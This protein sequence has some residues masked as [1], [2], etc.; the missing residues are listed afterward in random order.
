MGVSVLQKM[1]VYGGEGGGG[2]E[3]RGEGGL[4]V[5]YK[6]FHTKCVYSKRLILLDSDKCQ[7]RECILCAHIL[8]IPEYSKCCR[9]SW[10]L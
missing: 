10:F 7:T 6:G 4:G 8:Y 2:G 9:G 5:S 3:E 1:G